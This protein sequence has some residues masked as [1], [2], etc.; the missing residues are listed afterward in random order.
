MDADYS[1]LPDD[2]LKEVRQDVQRHLR[3]IEQEMAR[4]RE[5]KYGYPWWYCVTCDQHYRST[6]GICF[7]CD[8]TGHKME[9]GVL[10]DE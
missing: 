5:K 6:N 4:R 10:V 1:D 9:Q 8:E 3:A 7:F 2:E